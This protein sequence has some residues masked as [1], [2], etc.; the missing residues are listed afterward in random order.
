MTDDNTITR[1]QMRT[2]YI[3]TEL[4]GKTSDSNHFS[5]AGLGSST[6]SFGQL[7]FDVGHSDHAQDFLKENGFSDTDIHDLSLN[8]GLS[9]ERLGIL[10]AKLQAIP[11]AK[12]DQF[13]NDQ[14]DNRVA[15]VGRVIDRVRAHNPANADA[16]ARDQKLQLGL[17]DYANQFGSITPQLVEVMKGNAETLRATGITVQAGNP[18]TREDVQVFIQAG[19]YGHD[20]ANARG[21]AGRE[22]H[23]NKAIDELGLGS[24]AHGHQH[25]T[26]FIARPGSLRQGDR[27]EAVGIVQQELRDLGYTG[28]KGRPLTVDKDFGASTTAAIKAFQSEHALT[29]DGIVGKDTA[30]ALTQQVDVLQK[31][32]GP[33][34]LNAP[35]ASDAIRDSSVRN[36]FEAI[37]AATDRGMMDGTSAPTISGANRLPNTDSKPIPDHA[38]PTPASTHA[39][40]DPRHPENP[41]HAKYE[42]LRE[43][44][45]AAYDKHGLS[46]PPE[47]L[48][49]V[50]ASVML[51]ALKRHGKEIKEVHLNPAPG[52]REVHANSPVLAFSG[53]PK[54]VTTFKS[55]TDVQQARQTPPEQ[56]YQQL[57][58][59]QQ[60]QTQ[61]QAQVQTNTPTQPTTPGMGR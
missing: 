25:P 11:Q 12:I 3:A 56:S 39:P 40:S 36:A 19:K 28:S 48:E 8:G 22:A 15:E 16:I 4:G 60:Q 38:A 47:Q 5:Y 42:K 1:E 57:N 21:V 54:D 45:A 41:Q 17:A 30:N 23:F 53:D 24:A 35:N 9:R 31:N 43:Q 51:D 37:A 29:S 7:Q 2:V 59:L 6:Y 49:R 18:P 61:M 27:G 26:D 32:Q 50:T 52:T 20:P 33:N 46:L 34:A 55:I 58:Q 44:V 14:L 13:T 10:D